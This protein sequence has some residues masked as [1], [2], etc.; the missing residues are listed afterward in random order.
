MA[1]EEKT[2]IKDVTTPQK[3]GK[4]KTQADFLQKV[5]IW[6][7][8]SEMYFKQ[9]HNR[10]A[11]NTRLVNGIYE[12]EEVKKSKIRNR[13]K[14]FWR[15]TWATNMRLLASMYQSFLKDRQS[16]KIE[17]RFGEDVNRGKVLTEMCRYRIDLL[18]RQK[19]L[20]RKLMWA[21]L[22]IINLSD[23]I[24][25]WRWDVS[26]DSPDFIISAPDR[27]FPDPKATTKDRWAYCIFEDYYTFDEMKELGF[28][29][30][31]EVKSTRPTQTSVELSRA[32]RSSLDRRYISDSQDANYYPPDGSG[33]GSQEQDIPPL[34]GVWQVFYKEDGL[35]KY[36]VTNQSHTVLREGRDTG[37]DIYPIVHGS[38][39]LLAHEVMGEGFPEPLEGPQES[40]NATLNMRKD[41]VALS[42]VPH[43]IVARYAGVDLES[44]INARVGG[45]T[46]T[47][48]VNA[49]REED[50]RDVTSRAYLEVDADDQM[51]QEMSAVTQQRLGLPGQP[52]EKATVASI[53]Q[54][55][56]GTKLDLFIGIVAETFFRDFYTVLAHMIQKFETD[57][58]VFRVANA[59]LNN[60]VEILDIEN[61]ESD[62]IV[63]V[64]TPSVNRVTEIQ[65][66]FLAMDRMNISNQTALGFIQNGITENVHIF[67]VTQVMAEVLP[68]ISSNFKNLENFIVRIQQ[69]ATPAGGGV[70]GGG[71]TAPQQ[72]GV[73]EAL[74]LPTG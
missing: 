55:E 2:P 13:S 42:L 69:Q 54:Q 36:A 11:K 46:L 56:S 57:L 1:D 73:L 64:G 20:F 26:D 49:V 19:S 51:M 53:A 70:L 7:A 38:C 39:L 63:K 10:W 30:L 14:L 41:A 47:D 9:K 43:R 65:Q 66:L 44:L 71:A 25:F 31:D 23:A 67:N 34:Y 60:P 3:E 4:S 33:E 37:L 18:Y 22:D 28:K 21:L 52:G 6:K 17:G 15:K 74:G 68:L 16:M 8:D 12:E 62:F 58:T 50:K 48:D 40:A 61:F 32:E 45:I 29:N 5:S 59:K 35:I 27:V 72:A 24:G